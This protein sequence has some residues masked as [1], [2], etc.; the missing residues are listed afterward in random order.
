MSIN[1]VLTNALEG[2]A[3][4]ESDAYE[5]DKAIYLVFNYS[6]LPTD[7][8]DDAPSHER[9]L[10]QVHLYAPMGENVLDK[11]KAVKQA[12]FEAGGT[13]PSYTNTSDKEGQHHV[14]ECEFATKTGGD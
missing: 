6:T 1:A 8:G 10:V 5:G 7:F 3:P 14:F 11:R 2:I 4:V 13:W 9:H 12:L